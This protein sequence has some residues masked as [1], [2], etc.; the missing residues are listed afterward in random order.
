MQWNKQKEKKNYLNN[1]VTNEELSSTIFGV[2]KY[3]YNNWATVTEI[4]NSFGKTIEK[5]VSVCLGTKERKRK[6]NVQMI[7]SIVMS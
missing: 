1:F 6:K 2:L 3:N 7:I 4:K 5:C